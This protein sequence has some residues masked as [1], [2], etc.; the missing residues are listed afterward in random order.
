M[1]FTTGTLDWKNILGDG[2]LGVLYTQRNRKRLITDDS[3]INTEWS[4]GRT[5]SPLYARTRVITIEG[6]ID[7][8]GNAKEQEAVEYLENLFALQSD[9]GVLIPRVFHLVDEYWNERNINVKVKEPLDLVAADDGFKEAAYKRRVV[10]E[11]TDNPFFLSVDDVEQ[12]GLE[13]QYWGFSIDGTDWFILGLPRDEYFNFIE[14]ESTGNVQ[15]YPRFVIT[16]VWSVETPLII[17]NLTTGSEFKIDISAVVWDVIVVDADTYEIT[18]N[19]VDISYAR[20]EGSIW[21]VIN[22]VTRFGIEDAFWGIPDNDLNITIY[23]KN[24]LL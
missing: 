10:L 1:E 3:S 7:R 20:E 16:A 9:P 2:T 6:Y 17:R 4:H 23:F 15:S 12:S 14:C 8:L 24:C 11:S 18:K 22:G 5:T 19:W 13:W 21:P